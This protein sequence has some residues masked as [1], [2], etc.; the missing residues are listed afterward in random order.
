MLVGYDV[1]LRSKAFRSTD[2]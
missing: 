2:H 1:I